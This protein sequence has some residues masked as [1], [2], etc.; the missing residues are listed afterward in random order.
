[1]RI[2]RHLVVAAAAALLVAACGDDSDSD[3]SDGSAAPSVVSSAPAASTAPAASEPG[4]TEA[5]GST[6]S[7]GATEST[8]ATATDSTG[9]GGSSDASGEIVVW[10]YATT[11]SALEVQE[12]MAAKFN[13]SYPNVD[14]TFEFQPFEQMTQKL[15]TTA[16]Q[17]DG[18]DLVLYN[19]GDVYKL[20]DAKV[21]LPLDEYWG[22]WAEADQIAPSVQHEVDG[23]LYA[24]QPYV[25]LIALYY[26]KDVLAEAGVEPPSTVEELES[27]MQAVTDAGFQGMVMDGGP[28]VSGWWGGMPWMRGE[29]VDIQMS[30]KDKIAMVLERTRS[31][32]EKGFVSQDVVTLSQ[33]EAMDKFLAG[34]YGFVVNGNWELADATASGVNF[35]VVPI[36]DGACESSVYLGGEGASIGA[37]SDDP[38][39]AFEFLTLTYLSK[40]GGV[41]LIE[42][43]GSLS[44]RLDTGSDP[45]IAADENLSTYAGE[46]AGGTPLPFGPEENAAQSLFGDTWSGVL[47]GQFS[48]D[49][50]AAELVEKTPELLA[51]S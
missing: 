3:S 11:D 25:N 6:E 24:V 22:S 45:V 12:E 4:G 51:G 20:V 50:A 30:D 28:G 41:S 40:E 7:T 49:E 8:E 27:A 37:F 15:L 21:V 26:N 19:W 17:Q 36:P 33:A 32:I 10:H 18:P 48:A 39:L 13:E 29:C 23:A 16:A 47:A 14:V 44:T 31:W 1:M 38:Q 43:T 42:K 35:G 2:H 5:A 34:D 46:I 9:A